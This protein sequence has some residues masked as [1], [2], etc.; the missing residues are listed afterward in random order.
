MCW[1]VSVPRLPSFLR[2]TTTNGAAKPWTSNSTWSSFVSQTLP[3]NA[4][5]AGLSCA[6]LLMTCVSFM[7]SRVISGSSITHLSAPCPSGALG[8]SR[9]QQPNS[10]SGHAPGRQ[11]RSTTRRTGCSR[12]LV[13]RFSLW[14][15]RS[16]GTCRTARHPATRALLGLDA[17]AEPCSH[18]L[19]AALRLAHHVAVHVRGD[20]REDHEVAR[21]GLVD[22]L[23]EIA[24]Q[25]RAQEVARIDV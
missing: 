5:S 13:P 25:N 16:A 19:R 1:N 23:R 20:G 2:F 8:S 11:A 18:L 12:R 24:L 6:L 3:Y 9:N 21:I 7:R 15:A 14:C 22:G 10:E 17:L 4:T